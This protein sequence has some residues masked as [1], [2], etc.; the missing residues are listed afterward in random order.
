M[1]TEHHDPPGTVLLSSEQSGSIIYQPQPSDD[2]EDPLNWSTLRKCVNLGLVLSYVLLTFVVLDIP[3]V[4]YGQLVEDIGITFQLSNVAAALNF[5]GLAI[6]GVLLIPFT[7]RYGRRPIYVISI[8]VQL[9]AA[10]WAAR[11]TSK[12]EYLASSMLGGLGGAISETIVQI[13]I[14]DLVFVHQYATMNGVFLVTQGV[15]AYL[16]PVAAGYIVQSQGWRWMWWWCVIFIASTLVLVLLFFE[17]TTYVAAIDGTPV[18]ASP[19][20]DTDESVRKEWQEV[21]TL[22][23][24]ASIGSTPPKSAS[25]PFRGRGV[26]SSKPL[27][28]RLALVTHTEGPIKHHFLAPFTILFQFPA[29]AYTAVTVGSVMSW[30]A[31]MI[32]IAATRMIEPPY[33]FGPSAIG[34]IN[35]APFVGQLI[36]GL[37][38]APF[39]DKCIVKMARRNGGL[40]EPEMRLWLALP[41]AVLVPAGVLMFGIG[42]AHNAH[43]GVLTTGI[44]IFASGFT[45][46]VDIALAYLQ[47]CYPNIIGDAL[48]I[49]VFARN[50]IAVIILFYLSPWLDSMG[51]QNMFIM[52]GVL[53]FV[54]LLAPLPLLR[55]G[56]HARIMTT[57][58][59]QYHSLR[60]P[61]RRAM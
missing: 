3:P 53:S 31:V 17:E 7:Y 44:A 12:G 35:L 38:A 32:S 14:V 58:N 50:G 1:S 49:V 39:S 5:A 45:L 56:K 25:R 6:G 4:A 9:A 54:I 10:I 13:T 51:L 22:A 60:Q 52:I 29:V 2:P 41:G 34:L 23:N 16:G 24:T 28:K 27:R 8:A 61:S 46:A 11:I 40:Y 43:W 59:Y 30:M 42:I 18:A 20:D 48:V 15:G 37:L 33:N 47:D 21:N 55:W 26:T 19:K 36:S 57:K